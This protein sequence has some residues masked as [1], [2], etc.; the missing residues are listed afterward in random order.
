M[1]STDSQPMNLPRLGAL[2]SQVMDALWD[3][4]PGTIRDIINRL[5]TE[6]AYTTIATVL[7]N[8]DRKNLLTITREPRST[9]YAARINREEHAAELMEQVLDASHDRAA[10]ILH[11]VESMPDT[12]VDLLRDYLTRRHPEQAQ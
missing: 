5:N 8:L 10:S 11:F 9:H 3:K 4:G 2:E 6:P 1:S 7:T 12:D